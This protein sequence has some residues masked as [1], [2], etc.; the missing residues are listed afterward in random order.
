M[1]LQE[2]EDVVK[3]ELLKE[4]E[5]VVKQEF[6]QPKEEKEEADQANAGN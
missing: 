5:E 4:K 6:F 2:R 3:E 1:D